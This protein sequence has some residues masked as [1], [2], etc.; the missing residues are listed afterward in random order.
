M[1]KTTIH[2]NKGLK[3]FAGLRILFVLV[4]LISNYIVSVYQ[5]VEE[6]DLYLL[7]DCEYR[8]ASRVTHDSFPVK[9]HVG[10]IQ[11]EEKT[12]IDI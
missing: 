5:I 1:K 9:G 4:Q 8:E 3:R 6:R 7:A 10:A 11:L 2:A 12:S